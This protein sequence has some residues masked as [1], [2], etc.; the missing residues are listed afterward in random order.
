[1]ATLPSKYTQANIRKAFAKAANKSLFPKD[2]KR[3]LLKAPNSYVRGAVTNRMVSKQQAIKAFKYLQSQGKLKQTKAPSLTIN[4]A[5]YWQ[6]AENEAEEK[7]RKKKRADAE[8]RRIISDEAWQAAQGKDP[9]A[10]D[11][12]SL[13]GQIETKTP[14][15]KTT[16]AVN[17]LQKLNKDNQ[18]TN[19]PSPMRQPKKE[20][21]FKEEGAGEVIEMDI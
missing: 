13:L 4:K 6:L 18:T 1:M 2:F 11:P 16:S 3:T 10:H 7:K 14:N 8:N 21:L 12:R 9:L 17:N 15:Q 5:A 19:S 20:D